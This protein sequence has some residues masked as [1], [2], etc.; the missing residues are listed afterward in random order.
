ME[1]Q[2]DQ[3]S[4][5]MLALKENTARTTYNRIETLQADANHFKRMRNTTLLTVG[6][7]QRRATHSVI[8]R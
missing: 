1:H 4:D 3:V 5:N 2:G 6:S 7:R 8:P